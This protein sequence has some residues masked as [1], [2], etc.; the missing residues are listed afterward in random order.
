LAQ[1]ARQFLGV[2]GAY[3]RAR[4]NPGNAVGVRVAVAGARHDTADHVRQFDLVA[5]VQQLKLDQKKEI[6]L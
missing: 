3:A 2:L 6:P 5:R 4:Q 1:A